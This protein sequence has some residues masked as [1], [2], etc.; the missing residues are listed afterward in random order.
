MA[1]TTPH[2]HEGFGGFSGAALLTIPLQIEIALLLLH[3]LLKLQINREVTRARDHEPL[4]A[5]TAPEGDRPTGAWFT[6][7]SSLLV[8]AIGCQLRLMCFA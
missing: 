7:Q 5:N 4:T 1:L 2:G 6:L 8:V 3:G